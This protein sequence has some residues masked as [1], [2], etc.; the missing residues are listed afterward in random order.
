[1]GWYFFGLLIYFLVL[2]AESALVAVSPQEIEQLR[3][4]NGRTARRAVALARE[5]R[6]TMA[7][8]LLARLLLILML[9]VYPAAQLLKAPIVRTSLYET[10]QQLGLPEF[11]TWFAAAL[12]FATLVGIV[13]WGLQKIRIHKR[14]SGWAVNILKRLSYFI[15]FWNLIFKP[16]VGTAQ[17]PSSDLATN[18]ADSPDNIR[19]DQILTGLASEK[20]EIEL[21]KSIVKFGDVTVKQVMQPRSKVVA[22]D[23]KVGFHDLLSIVREAGFSRLPVYQEDLDNV[24][25]ILYVK[26]ML[27]HLTKSDDFEWQSLIRTNV[28]LAP[29]SKRGTELLQDFKR[30]KIHMAIVVD[31]YGGSSGIVT[32]ED[33]L[34]EVTG[35]IRDEF[36]EESEVRYR[37]LDDHNYIFEGQTLLSDVCRIVGLDSS[38]FDEARGNADTLAGLVLELKGDIPKSGAE[39]TW[40]GFMI[41]VTAANS[42]RIE[43][44][45]LGLPRS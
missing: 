38:T 45:K 24:T 31:E 7:S 25:G 29:E 16:L 11:F 1:M 28:M 42:R 2:L 8:L 33:V 40:N 9:V 3:N 12:A 27:P 44:L 14:V 22:V 41:T 17:E 5:I 19:A 13:F 37:K 18:G 43:Q 26:D 34:E 10:S 23:F 21:L 4:E 39:I 6:P 35:E 30:Q 20:R 15:T 32:L 36:D